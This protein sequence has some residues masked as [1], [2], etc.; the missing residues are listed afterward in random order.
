MLCNFII[1]IY[2]IILLFIVVV[3]K[4]INRNK[5][6][7]CINVIFFNIFNIMNKDEEY[8]FVLGVEL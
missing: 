7:M 1:Y 3:L 5:Y 6:Y 2:Y 8:F 4:L